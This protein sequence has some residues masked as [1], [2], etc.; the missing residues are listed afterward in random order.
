M[1]DRRTRRGALG[2]ALAPAGR[3][4]PL[5]SRHPPGLLERRWRPSATAWVAPDSAGDALTSHPVKV[6][7]SSRLYH[8]PGMLAYDRTRPDRCYLTAEA[9]EADGFVRAKR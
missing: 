4:P 6:K 3:S 1:V 7:E 5:P 9:A 2:R 8:L